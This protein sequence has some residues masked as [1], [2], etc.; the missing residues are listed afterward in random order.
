MAIRIHSSNVT[1][2]D[3]GIDFDVFP[4]VMDRRLRCLSEALSLEDQ[5]SRLVA[6]AFVGDAV[7]EFVRDVCHWAGDSSSAAQI[8]EQNAE[9]AVGQALK[10]ACG[11][12]IFID[13]T[14]P[15][16]ALVAVASLKG[17]GSPVTASRFLRFLDAKHCP[18]LDGTIARWF[19]YPESCDGYDFYADDCLRIAAA[20]E[21][22]SK[23]NPARPD[24]FSWAAADVGAVLSSLCKALDRLASD[25]APE[26]DRGEQSRPAEWCNFRVSP[27]SC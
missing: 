25:E 11:R 4:A 5:A 23:W 13:P 21:V 16:D 24:G 17:V 27:R 8:M 1:I 3:M 20:L 2:K 22:A 10:A 9:G 26:P 6:G 15:G 7:T 18:A 12:L 19:G 14:A